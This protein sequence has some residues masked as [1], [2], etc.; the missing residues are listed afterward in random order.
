MA[1]AHTPGPWESEGGRVWQKG[2]FDEPIAY[3]EHEPDAQLMA[4]APAMLAALREVEQAWCGDSDMASAVD[5]ALLAIAAATEGAT[6]ETE[7][8][9]RQ[10]NNLAAAI[11]AARAYVADSDMSNPPTQ[12]QIA[13]LLAEVG[14]AAP[15][16]AIRAGEY[17]L[18]ARADCEG[19]TLTDKTGPT[20]CCHHI[21]ADRLESVLEALAFDPAETGER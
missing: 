11:N 4:A 7:R 15:V 8:T 5:S 17:Q 19:F 13:E 12:A 18:E 14:A 16:V 9:E 3:V 6:G 20:P 21:S 1:Q 10:R 2:D